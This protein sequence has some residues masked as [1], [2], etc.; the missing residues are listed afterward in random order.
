MK[1]C[2]LAKA[3]DYTATGQERKDGYVAY[4]IMVRLIIKYK[5]KAEMQ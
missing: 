4:K 1:L 5:Y 2:S 3:D